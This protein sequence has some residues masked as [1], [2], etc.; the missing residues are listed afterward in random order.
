MADP[1]TTDHRVAFIA[2]STWHG[3]LERA[4]AML[5]ADPGLASRDIHTA[6]ILG[7]VDRVRALLARDPG[8]VHARSEPYGANA[9]THL[10]LSKYLRLDPARSDAF[11]AAATLLLDAGA[12][13]N[14]GFWTTG[15]HPEHETP[16]YGAAG[17]AH[18]APLTRLL[19]DRGADPNDEEAVYHSPESDDCAAMALLV[20]TGRLTN[21]HLSL[22]LIRKHDWHDHDGARY[23]L[24][25]GA[26]ANGEGRTRG[27]RPLHHALARSNQLATIELLLNHGANPTLTAGDDGLTGVARAARE[28][29]RD[30]LE[31]FVRRGTPLDLPG[32]DRLIAA[33]AMDDTATVQ[34]LARQEPALRDAV[35]AMGGSLLPTFAGNGN[36]AGVG[37][38]LDLGVDVATPFAEGDGY[39]GEPKGSL[40]IHVAAWRA[41]P[42]VVKL[43]LE[44]GSPVDPPDPTGRTPLALAIRACVDSHWAYRRTPESVEALLRAGASVHGAGVPFPSGYAEVDDL[45]RRHGA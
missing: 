1:S 3:T 40:A 44:R 4:D 28:G 9:L 31:L 34:S 19:L 24:E 14:A 32:V 7:D 20:E 39:F 10:C 37:Q 18:H 11:V 13:P 23:L 27:W 16:L 25:H 26:D 41:Y 42:A 45:L 17:V 29:R 21:E 15:Q 22:M 6:A 5:T 33:C 43:L 2:A 8:C 30:V 36:A 35:V 38:L 12:D